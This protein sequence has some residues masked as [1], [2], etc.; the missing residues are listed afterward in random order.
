MHK[1]KLVK[2]C[3]LL[4]IFA[5]ILRFVEFPYYWREMCR[6][7]RHKKRNNVWHS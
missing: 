4:A 5:F 1:K 6:L 3:D 2:I 7:E